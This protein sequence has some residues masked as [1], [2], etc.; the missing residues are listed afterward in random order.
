[1]KT[2]W[3]FI[4]GVLLQSMINTRDIVLL[5]AANSYLALFS[6]SIG[7]IIT[8]IDMLRG[9]FGWFVGEETFNC[10]FRDYVL[11]ALLGVIFNTF[12][13]QVKLFIDRSSF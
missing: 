2:L 3:I 8:N 7:S 5:L 10:R 6:F 11:Y 9:D 13:L 4:L 1:M 12:G